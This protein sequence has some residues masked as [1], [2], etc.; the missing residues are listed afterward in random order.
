G[1]VLHAQARPRRAEGAHG[2]NPYSPTEKNK[3]P[4]STQPHASLNPQLSVTESDERNRVKRGR[5]SVESPKRS[6]TWVIPGRA[7]RP[8]TTSVA[9]GDPSAERQA[10][11]GAGRP[12][13]GRPTGR[14]APARGVLQL[15]NDP[16]QAARLPHEG[17]EP[18]TSH[19]VRGSLY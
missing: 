9:S 13:A 2:P 5:A 17:E 19:D 16:G 12:P 14:H 3:P 11:C 1:R 10:F 8:R 7:A 4:A 18:R 6:P 15:Q